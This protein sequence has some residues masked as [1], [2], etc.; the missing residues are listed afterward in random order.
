MAADEYTKAL[1]KAV[2]DLEERVRNR[3]LLSAEIAGLRETVRVLSNLVKMT[4]ERLKQVAQLLAMVDY[5]TPNL[6]DAIRSLLIHVY[7]KE[8]TAI[9][10]RNAL[11][12]SSDFEDL[13]NSLSACHAA[14]KRIVSDGDAEQGTP[15]DGKT[16]YRYILHMDPPQSALP[17]LQDLVGMYGLSE[18]GALNQN[19]PVRKLASQ[20]LGQRIAERG[21]QKTGMPPPPKSYG[22]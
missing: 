2:S 8:M 10:V 1:D 19:H 9:E 12:D 3:Y 16:T 4:P 11:E 13:S 20:T 18:P 6:T 22:K 7:P 17:Y 15:K 14:L 5:A 21:T